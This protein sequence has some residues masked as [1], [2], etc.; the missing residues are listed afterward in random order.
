MIFKPPCNLRGLCAS[1]V[2][3]KAM[4][5]QL[6]E[7]TLDRRPPSSV[8]CAALFMAARERCARKDWSQRARP[9]IL[10]AKFSLFVSLSRLL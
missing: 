7:L 9:L 5:T 2:S 1:V 4:H 8:L 3:L 6:S 10:L